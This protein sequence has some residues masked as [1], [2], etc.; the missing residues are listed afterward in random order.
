MPNYKS[1]SYICRQLRLSDQYLQLVLDGEKTSTIRKKFL[2]FNSI[3]IP[4]IVKGSKVA[5][6]KLLKID[7]SKTFCT[8]EEADAIRDGFSSL[9]D[10]KQALKAHYSDIKD[11][12]PLTIIH[13][14]LEK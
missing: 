13:F 2:L 12:Y 14:K 11:D 4:L 10:L 7:Y 6:L 8:L 5:N 3:I 9:S 1:T